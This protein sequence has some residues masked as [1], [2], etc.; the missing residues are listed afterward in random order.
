MSYP[1]FRFIVFSLLLLVIQS[2][3]GR[4]SAQ[5]QPRCQSKINAAV[6]DS[7]RPVRIES[8][9]PDDCAKE[10]LRFTFAPPES[11][12]F[13]FNGQTLVTQDS[14]TISQ[15]FQRDSRLNFDFKLRDWP[16]FA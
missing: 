4:D 3:I 2:T 12:T 7:E 5:A 16:L 11:R 1:T 14:V 8:A 10:T 13:P 15:L 9:N 6:D